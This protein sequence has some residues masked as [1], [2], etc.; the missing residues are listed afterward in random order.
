MTASTRVG[1]SGA[2]RLGFV[3]GHQYAVLAAREKGGSD[4]QAGSQ[5]VRQRMSR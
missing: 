4:S 5:S 3:A 2:E 1:D